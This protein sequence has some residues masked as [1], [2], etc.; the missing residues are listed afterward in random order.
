MVTEN[1][2]PKDSID[3]A[4]KTYSE[5][6]TRVNVDAKLCFDFLFHPLLG[7]LH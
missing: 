6:G 5:D 7:R 3:N 1:N 2:K 4:S